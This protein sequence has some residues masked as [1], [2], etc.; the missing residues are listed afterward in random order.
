MTGKDF[1]QKHLIDELGNITKDYPFHAV[2]LMAIGIEFLGKCLIANPDWK[3]TDGKKHKDVFDA[4]LDKYDPLI[5]YKA[6]NGLYYDLRCSFAHH[7]MVEGDLTLS[8]N[9][10]NDLA[11]KQIDY[12]CLFENFK[13]ACEIAI[14]NTNG[15]IKKNLDEDY[16]DECGGITGA[17]NSNQ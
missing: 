14:S 7:F 15:L 1:I 10:S 8:N 16:S 9:G 12:Q 17:T 5:K 4:A 6:I 13:K 11:V 2:A 3:D